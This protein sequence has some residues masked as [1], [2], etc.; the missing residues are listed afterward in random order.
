MMKAIGKGSYRNSVTISVS[1]HDSRYALFRRG[2]VDNLYR[3]S[4]FQIPGR[5]R[6]GLSMTDYQYS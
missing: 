5:S 2:A 6:R 3:M 4:P 1:V